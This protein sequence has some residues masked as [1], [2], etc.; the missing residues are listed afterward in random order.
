MADSTDSTSKVS[1]YF[2]YFNLEGFMN[3]TCMIDGNLETFPRVF[4]RVSTK[5]VVS[6]CEM[7]A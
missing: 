1:Y 5:T 4:I 3:M 2:F 6:S 7:K